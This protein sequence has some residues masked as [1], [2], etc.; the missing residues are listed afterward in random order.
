MGVVVGEPAS[1]GLE[2]WAE[3]TTP[4]VTACNVDVCEEYEGE[5]GVIDGDAVGSHST[6]F[7]AKE[8][9]VGGD[10]L[11]EVKFE[12]DDMEELGEDVAGVWAVGALDDGGKDFFEEP[13]VDATEVGAVGGF[14][15][16]VGDV[17]SNF[18]GDGVG[19]ALFGPDDGLVDEVD[20]VG[21]VLG[22]GAGGDGREYR[23]L[24]G[25]LRI[26]DG[27]RV[28]EDRRD[29]G[30]IGGPDASEERRW[31]GRAADEQ[32]FHA[33][34]RIAWVV[35]AFEHTKDTRDERSD[36]VVGVLVAGVARQRKFGD[37]GLHMISCGGTSGETC[38]GHGGVTMLLQK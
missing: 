30:D 7:G 2:G 22:V 28:V 14:E 12:L 3:F 19:G 31:V 16:C 10:F 4:V 37:G 33:V 25:G 11:A 26:C 32:L 5:L 18:G 36:G 13:V 1:D 35:G 38:I 27:A 9:H 17:R 8:L 23:E 29:R 20:L 24:C 34:A 15:D 21:F 6:C